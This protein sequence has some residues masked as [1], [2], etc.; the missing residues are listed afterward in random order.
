MEQ[1]NYTEA[2]KALHEALVELKA[3]GKGCEKKIQAINIILEKQGFKDWG[4]GAAVNKDYCDIVHEGL[5]AKTK[6]SRES[7]DKKVRA[8]W[9]II[10][11]IL[12]GYGAVILFILQE[13]K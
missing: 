7:I 3:M 10:A 12:T 9:M 2:L 8:A 5:V 13:I 11:F 1:N 4:A 6:D